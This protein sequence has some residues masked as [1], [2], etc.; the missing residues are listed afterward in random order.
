VGVEYTDPGKVSEVSVTQVPVSGQTATRYGAK[1]P[2]CHMIK[3]DG[4]WRRVYVMNYSTPYVRV[5][6]RDVVLDSET[7]HRLNVI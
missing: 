3:Y 7:Q 2:T 4:A 1:I 5:T 6:G